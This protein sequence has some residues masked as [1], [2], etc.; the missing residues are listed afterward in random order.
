MLEDKSTYTTQELFDEL[1][2]ALTELAR[3]SGIN[4]VTLARIRD[5]KPTRRSTLNKLLL[6][7][8]NIYG[9]PLSARNVTGVNVQANK[10][11]ERKADRGEAIT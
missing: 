7:L 2:L 5:G 11:L 8:S 4:E 1:P 9:R 6:T 3:Q 10:R